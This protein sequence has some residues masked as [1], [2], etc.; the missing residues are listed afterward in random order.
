M[1]RFSKNQKVRKMKKKSKIEKIFRFFFNFLIFLKITSSQS[2]LK[3]DDV[4]YDSILLIMW[5]KLQSKCFYIQF[6]NKSFSNDHPRSSFVHSFA[7]PNVQDQLGSNFSIVSLVGLLYYSEILLE[8]F[9]DSFFD[10][11][12]QFYIGRVKELIPTGPR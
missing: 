5:K 1:L 10:V 9:Q 3:N 6:P 8:I 2:T 7:S 12:N 11:F 4:T